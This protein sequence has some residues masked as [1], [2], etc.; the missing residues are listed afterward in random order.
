MASRSANVILQHVR[1]IQSGQT[2][3]VLADRDLLH[4]FAGGDEDAFAALVRRHGPMVLGVGRRVLH[5]ASDADDVFQAAFLALARDAGSRRWQVSVGNWLY[6]VA[7]RLALNARAESECRARHEARARLAAPMDPLAIVTGR[8]LCAILDEELAR[9]PERLRAPL[10]S[11]CLQGQT[12]DEAARSLGWSLGTLKRRLEQGRALLRSRL[13]KRGFTLPATLA[14]TL[15]AEGIAP[16]A[17][18]ADLIQTVAATAAGGTIPSVRVLSLSQTLSISASFVRLKTAAVVFLAVGLIGGLALGL[19]PQ[20]VGWVES[21]RPTGST[22]PQQEQGKNTVGPGDS[23]HPTK[24]ER[25][26]QHGDPLPEGAIARL[27]TIHWRLDSGGAQCMAIP[28]DGKTLV[29]ANPAT[30]VIIWELPTG[31]E[32]R[33]VPYTAE[34]RKAWL[35]TR[36][37]VT[38]SLDGSTVGFGTPD[39]IVHIVDVGSGKVKQTCRGHQGPIQEA[40]LSADGRVLVT[41]SGDGTLRVWDAASGKQVHLMRIESK[42]QLQYEP[43]ELALSPDGKTF[44][45]IG[46][47]KERIIHVCDA[48]TCEERHRLD[49]HE[50]DYR[51]MVFSPGS[52]ALVA[53]SDNGRIQLWDVNLGR[54]VRTWTSGGWGIPGIAFAPDGKTLAVR[55]GSD[56]LRLLD[57]ATGTE[58]WSIKQ[59]Y[60]STQKDAFAF[61]PDGKTLIVAPFGGPV[62]CRYETAKGK[63]LLSEGELT[64]W[65]REIAF[66]ADER[67]LYSLHED[68]VLHVWATA[69]GKELRHTEIGE[70]WGSFSPDGRLLAITKEGTAHLFDV[71]AGKEFRQLKA[72]PQQISSLLFSPDGRL[73]LTQGDA[74]GL[75]LWNAATGKELRRLPQM[76]ESFHDFA[77]TS[78][79]DALIG[80]GSVSDPEKDCLIRLWDVATGRERRTIN[81][82]PSPMARI[83]LSPDGKTL[84]LPDGRF[85]PRVLIFWEI[86]TGQKRLEI[87]QARATLPPV[88]RFSPDGKMLM[89]APGASTQFYD[90]FTGRPLYR[91]E[92]PRGAIGGFVFSPSGRL[93]ATRSTDYT[94]LVWNAADFLRGEHPKPMEPAGDDLSAAWTDL[95]ASDGS[96]AYQAIGRLVGAQGKSVPWLR[97]HLRAIPALTADEI[98]RME[99]LL[100]DLD[101]EQFDVRRKAAT[102]IEQL[103]E[104]VLPI[105]DKVLEGTPSPEVRSQ[106]EKLKERCT[107]GN[108]GPSLRALRAVEVLE[109]IN[110]L[111]TRQLLQKLAAGTP[112]ARLTREAKAA[113]QRLAKR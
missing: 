61:T 105:L 56:A 38:L 53:T 110:T 83:G 42:K 104:P 14:G 54:L 26:D 1:G 46:N 88:L 59:R 87:E 22:S 8:E 79:S 107:P 111:E 57:V 40:A 82:P 76:K 10:I 15:V 37:S 4:R 73:L 112:E 94:T 77:F 33:K 60:G 27:G 98:K 29:T 69:T 24:K 91:R 68:G 63:R 55:R 30:G 44:A 67:T 86:A 70:S 103:G 51:H 78:D 96:K 71:A 101:N 49:Q 36:S 90:A 12:R 19:N 13:E 95:A 7:Y 16:A 47:D 39:G 58:L 64:A 25:T 109:H 34:L 11:C 80:L 113:L 102:E 92:G 50:G 35:D 21:A 2:Y 74:D 18:P 100:V 84:V 52:Q 41:R 32:V 28:H 31:K 108:T 6:V 65:F 3:G 43:A 17:V 20:L 75:V 72:R 99:R 81:L 89:V 5:Q 9:L 93:V 62:L 66:S 45:W 85:R 106:V 48:A 97:E 23:T